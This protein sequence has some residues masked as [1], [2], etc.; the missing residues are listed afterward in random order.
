[1]SAMVIAVFAGGAAGS[2][3]R[4]VLSG[5]V[6]ARFGTAFPWGTLTVNVT[7]S[8]LLGLAIPSFTAT[9]S[10]PLPGFLLIGC[11]G[12]FTTFST[13]SI[14]AL[15]LL[16]DGRRLTAAIYVAVSLIAGLLSVALGIGVGTLI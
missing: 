9:G 12:A 7:G 1:M 6:Y 15:I 16:R 10:S 3:A 14:E 11:F 8:F 5:W 13:F 4:F 2:V